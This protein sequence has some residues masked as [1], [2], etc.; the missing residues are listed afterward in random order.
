M[1]DKTHLFKALIICQALFYVF[2]MLGTFNIVICKK[3]TPG[4]SDDKHIFLI[5]IWSSST[6]PGLQ[7]LKPLEIPKVMKA[8]KVSFIMLMD[9]FWPTPGN[10]GWLPG[11]TTL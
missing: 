6:V 9:D 2:Y 3:Y 10:G 5:Y 11:E 4:H 8:Q 1:D 7:L